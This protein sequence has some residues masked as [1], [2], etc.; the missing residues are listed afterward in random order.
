MLS[1]IICPCAGFIRVAQSSMWWY[2]SLELRWSDH[3]QYLVTSHG[4]LQLLA[5]LTPLCQAVLTKLDIFAMTLAFSLFYLD[6]I[7]KLA[8][9]H[10]VILWGEI[11]TLVLV[12]N[13]VFFF[14]LEAG[15]FWYGT[16]ARE[17]REV[18]VLNVLDLSFIDTMKHTNSVY[19]VSVIALWHSTERYLHR[20]SHT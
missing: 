5:V 13:W 4:T 6:S 7:N 2:S 20:L 9:L 18:P 14:F 16:L 15:H 17:N 12:S 8:K 10:S 11:L 3:C 19:T 1:S